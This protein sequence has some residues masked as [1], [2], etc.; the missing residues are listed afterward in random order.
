[1]R[2]EYSRVPE[3]PS[4]AWLAKLEPGNDCVSVQCGVRL[5][6]NHDWFCEAVWVGDYAS[7]DLDQSDIVAGSGAR[8]R[9]EELIFASAGATVDRLVSIE[10]KDAFY[11]SNSLP[12]I[13]G[14]R[15]RYRSPA[16]L[17]TL[18]I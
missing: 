6:T 8:I 5:E 16:T 3:W 11:V 2:L 17:I 4:L 13:L 12:C 18:Q 9:N 1:M 14:D 15:C 10:A 7:G